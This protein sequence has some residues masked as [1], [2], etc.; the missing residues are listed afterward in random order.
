MKININ[1]KSLNFISLIITLIM[2]FLL[3]L[4]LY[5]ISNIFL[6]KFLKNNNLNKNI[7]NGRNDGNID[8]VEDIERL[9]F[10]NIGLKIGEEEVQI[11]EK[12]IE[13]SNIF[14]LMVDNNINLGKIT[15]EDRIQIYEKD[16]F[17]NFYPNESIVISENEIESKIDGF[18]T[19]E[20][21]RKIMDKSNKNLLLIIYNK[22]G[23]NNEKIRLIMS[24]KKIKIN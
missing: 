15:R 7:K 20:E 11:K 24:N 23:K 13:N 17:I 12:R 21:E 22:V 14:I 1:K 3:I 16:T 19:N 5:F 10:Y 2:F 4:F 9:N 18:I 8:S 6:D